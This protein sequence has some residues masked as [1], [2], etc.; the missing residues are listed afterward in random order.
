MIPAEEYR[1]RMERLQ[2]RVA[3]SGLAAF[4][5]S[6]EES[7]YY[8]TGVSYKSLERPFFII[9][10]P[11]GDPFL[12]VPA[13]ERDHLRAASNV[14]EVEYYWDYPAPAGQGW[15]ERLLGLLG[16]VQGL[17]VEPSLPQA[18]GVHLA[19]LSPRVLPLVEG[20]RQV[21]SPAE[22][23]MLRTA[24]RYADRTVE[25]ILRVS[26][27]GASELEVFAQSRAVQAQIMKEVG[28]EPLTTSVLAATWPAPLSAQPHGV[29]G[30]GD[31]LR[32]G[33]HIALGFLRV[34][35]YA[36]E[37][38]RTYFLTPPTA[39]VRE[40][41]AAI[42]EARRRAFALVRPGVPCAAV[43]RAT[44]EF[45]TAEGYGPYL[46]HRT[47]HGFG[48]GNHEAPWVAEG[49]SELL[50]ENM[51][52]SVEPGI[53]LPGVG[54]IRHSDTTLVTRDGYENLTRLPTDLAAMTLRPAGPLTRLRGL[55]MRQ[56]AGIR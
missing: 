47:G 43:D 34:N 51:V 37:C 2:L 3:D 13:L 25:R 31:R 26:Y 41:F 36:A 35:G 33:P 27:Y 44:R 56:A 24:A 55:F 49:S 9:V 21:K 32:E 18:I 48:L 28:Y 8:L 4:L 17:G 54:G 1:D 46:L 6:S 11:D 16:D 53:Y 10:W 38:E 14:Q 45:L 5:V 7:I 39:Q 20:L 15:P 50:A 19:W 30:I 40:A 12:L 29:P 22:V 42:L 52:I 23:A